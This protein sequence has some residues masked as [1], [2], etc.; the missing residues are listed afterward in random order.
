MYF[1]W[2]KLAP[3]HY[4][5]APQMRSIELN[6][7]WTRSIRLSYFSETCVFYSL[8]RELFSFFTKS[9]SRNF[10]QPSQNSQFF[11]TEHHIGWISTRFWFEIKMR[12]GTFSVV[13]CILGH[14]GN[15]RP[16]SCPG[17]EALFVG[18]LHCMSFNLSKLWL[19]IVAGRHLNLCGQRSGMKIW[20]LREEYAGLYIGRRHA[21]M[22]MPSWWHAWGTVSVLFLKCKYV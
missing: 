15:P 9:K 22:K 1:T 3:F 8:Q 2:Y 12:W 6:L 17:H 18:N 19:W 14:V 7:Y 11:S 10:Q 20:C 13:L 16:R 5:I 4:S 21:V